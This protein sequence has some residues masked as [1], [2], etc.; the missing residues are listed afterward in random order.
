[1]KADIR[2]TGFRLRTARGDLGGLVRMVD[3]D[4]YGI[5]VIH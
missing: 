3:D 2:K 1:V 5:D 4:H